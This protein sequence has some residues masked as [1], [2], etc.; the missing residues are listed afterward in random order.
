MNNEEMKKKIEELEK[1]MERLTNFSLKETERLEKKIRVLESDLDDVSQ[2]L[3]Q[4]MRVKK[5][6]LEIEDYLN[7]KHNGFEAHYFPILT[8]SKK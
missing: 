6:V 1:K 3:E 8:Y 2:E 5:A 7:K 4:A